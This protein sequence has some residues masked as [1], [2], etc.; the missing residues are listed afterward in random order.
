MGLVPEIKMDWIELDYVMLC[1]IIF[2][3]QT[4]HAIIL[5]PETHQ[6]EKMTK[7]IARCLSATAG[8]S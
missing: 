3:L 8:L 4:K 1:N 7:C 5:K 6:S 2:L